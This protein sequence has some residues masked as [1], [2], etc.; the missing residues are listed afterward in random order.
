M[1]FGGG[2]VL[3]LGYAAGV[4]AVLVGLGGLTFGLAAL[5]FGEGTAGAVDLV[6]Q[7]GPVAAGA[8]GLLGGA[9]GEEPVGDPA[10]SG[11][12]LVALFPGGLA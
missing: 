5:D 9:A 1:V 10:V 8:A 12:G 2:G 6:G 7:V 3:V 4:A 11:L